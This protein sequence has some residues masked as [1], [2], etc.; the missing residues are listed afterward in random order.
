MRSK[1]D[2][3]KTDGN[4][5]LEKIRNFVPLKISILELSGEGQLVK[6]LDSK[7]T[8]KGHPPKGRI[9]RSTFAREFLYG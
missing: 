3:S 9:D 7:L 4:R 1:F 5:S 6:S 2:A 8:I